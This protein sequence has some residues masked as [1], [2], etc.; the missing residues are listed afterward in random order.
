[1][2]LTDVGAHAEVWETVVKKLRGRMMPP[3]GEPLPNEQATTELVAYLEDQLDA[4]AAA[5]PN[6]GRKSLHRL[7]RTEY[8]NAIRDLL[9]L[10]INAN[11]FLPNDSEAYGF[12]NIA[13]VL[14]TDPSLMDR[15]L[16]AAW[17]VT[18]AAMGDTDIAPAVSTYRVPPDR[19]QT[20]HVEGL[21]L[22]TRGGM[23]VSHH[24]PVDGEYVIKPR[25]WRNTVDVVRGT[26]TPHDL[27]VSLD[28]E[29][30]SLTRFGGPEDEV[31]A[32]MFPGKTADEIDARFETVVTVAAGQ[33]DVGVTFAKK[34]SATRQDVLQPF[35]REKHDARMDVGIPELDQIVIEGP[36]TIAGPGNSPSRARIFSCYPDSAAEEAACATEILSTTA[37][38]AYR[39]PITDAE[40]DRLVGLYDAERAKGRD[41]EAGVQ[42]GLAYVLVAP[43]FLFRVE[44]DPA[45]AE[46]GTLYKV[47]DVELATRL[48]FF[49]WS[50]LPDD[51]LVEAA[52]AGKLSQPAELREQV[53]RMLAD[54]RATTLAKSFASQWLYL[55]N[56]RASAPDMYF[57]PDF[58][59]NLRQSAIRETELLF[60]TIIR[61][62]RP[63]T[64]LLSADYTFMNE[65]LARHY[66]VPGHLRRSVPPHRAHGHAPPRLAR[67]GQHSHFELVPEPHLAREPR[68][69]RADEHLGH[70]AA[71]AAARRADAAR[72]DGREAVDARAHGAPPRR[73]GLRRLPPAHGPDR[74]RAR[75]LR[76]HRP[77]GAP[78]TT[79]TPSTTTAARSTC[80]AIS[81][82]STAPKT[83]ARPF[84]ASPSGSFERAPRS[85]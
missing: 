21:P 41:F 44:Q 75:A 22:G 24:F 82:R 51:E 57:F 14:G 59:D 65:R 79:A 29:R 33:H 67:P 68:Q 4:A 47:G 69:L 8:G 46:P 64:E 26:E 76:R 13:D 25:L 10:E 80:C 78:R 38:R 60:E 30:L 56:L 40:R 31:P 73:P 55:R 7:N 2:A 28:G 19:S 84:S 53:E 74:P 35:A 39:R 54:E 34:S 81:G 72:S 61:E 32:Q 12:D 9:A 11:A 58:D 71:G 62:D 83:C 17:K 85:S 37:R 66:G 3:A 16:S 50:S 43:Q 15:Y 63:L 20:D 48:S 36:L 18:S 70:A 27:E 52:V 77:A 6:P 1:M 23:L 45:G 49:L 42:T 5:N